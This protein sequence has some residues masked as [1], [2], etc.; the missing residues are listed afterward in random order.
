MEFI[1]FFIAIVV[2]ITLEPILTNNARIEKIV[3]SNITFYVSGLLV[4]IGSLF[5]HEGFKLFGEHGFSNGL[6]YEERFG[7][8]LLYYWIALWVIFYIVTCVRIHRSHQ[9]Y[10]QQVTDPLAVRRHLRWARFTTLFPL[11]ML[12]IA[13]F[14]VLIYLASGMS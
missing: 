3:S 4:P 9:I 12:L 1:F 8:G 6:K 13:G 2:F 11:G 7:I 10:K 5:P 14:G